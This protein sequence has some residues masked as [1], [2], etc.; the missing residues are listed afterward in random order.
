MRCV[1]GGVMG[2]TFTSLAGDLP[3]SVSIRLDR[4]E[5][6]ISSLRLRVVEVVRKHQLV[7]SDKSLCEIAVGMR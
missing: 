6:S 3:A 5:S 7:S 4:L 2:L 1:D